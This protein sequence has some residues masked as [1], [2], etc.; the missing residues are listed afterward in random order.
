M[1]QYRMRNGGAVRLALMLL[2]QDSGLIFHE[3]SWNSRTR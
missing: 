1:I 3:S 2:V